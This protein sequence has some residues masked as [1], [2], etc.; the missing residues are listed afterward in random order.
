MRDY[1]LSVKARALAYSRPR[2]L[3]SAAL[4][5][6]RALGMLLRCGMKHKSSRRIFRGPR[7]L[8]GF[9][10]DTECMCWHFVRGE[11]TK[12]GAFCPLWNSR[13]RVQHARGSHS[14]FPRAFT[15]PAFHVWEIRGRLREFC[16]TLTSSTTDNVALLRPRTPVTAAR[17][18]AAEIATPVLLNCQHQDRP[19]GNRRRHCSASLS[20]V[21]VMNET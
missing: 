11:H 17:K 18:A 16:F 20:G 7:G 19:A 6:V 10:A 21:M 4:P 3:S 9:W 2:G 13:P 15:R 8:P 12:H 14:N 1:T 5:Y